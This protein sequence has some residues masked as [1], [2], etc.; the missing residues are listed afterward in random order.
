MLAHMHAHTAEYMQLC[1]RLS[2]VCISGTFLV[3]SPRVFL[4]VKAQFL[5]VAHTRR[6]LDTRTH[7]PVFI[8]QTTVSYWLI[9]FI[10]FLGR[11]VLSSPGSSPLTSPTILIWLL[12]FFASTV[13]AEENKAGEPRS[14]RTVR[15]V[16]AHLCVLGSVWFTLRLVAVVFPACSRKC[17]VQITAHCGFMKACYVE[18]PKCSPQDLYFFPSENTILPFCREITIWIIFIVLYL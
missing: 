15:G 8:S 13:G 6:E 4:P 7:R 17:P 14:V 11:S 10:L 12:S 2:T 1:S 5:S 18:N 16:A 9:P 3:A